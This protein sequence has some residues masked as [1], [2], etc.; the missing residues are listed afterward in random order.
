MKKSILIIA[1]AISI[2]SC[3]EAA[4]EESFKSAYIDTS[5]LIKNF[6]EV[7]NKPSASIFVD[8]KDKK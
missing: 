3:K 2:I 6:L 5:E 1:L 4:K 7:N 8:N